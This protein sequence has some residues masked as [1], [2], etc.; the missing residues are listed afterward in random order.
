MN[1]RSSLA[2]LALGLASTMAFA[3]ALQQLQP[4]PPSLLP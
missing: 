4:P 1:I 2:I 3:A